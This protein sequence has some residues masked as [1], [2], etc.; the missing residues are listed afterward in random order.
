LRGYC[1]NIDQQRFFLDGAIAAPLK[2]DRQPAY[3]IVLPPRLFHCP[4]W[5]LNRCIYLIVV[6][7]TLAM[8][9]WGQTDE[10]VNIIPRPAVILQAENHCGSAADGAQAA[11]PATYFSENAVSRKRVEEEGIVLHRPEDI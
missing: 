4:R 5:A 9:S 1:A 2:P 8:S 10:G 11:H 7:R 6:T 3:E